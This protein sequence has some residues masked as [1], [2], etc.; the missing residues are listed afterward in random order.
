VFERQRIRWK[1]HNNGTKFND[2][3]LGKSNKNRLSKKIILSSSLFGKRRDEIVESFFH[4]QIW[5]K[6]GARVAEV[7]GLS[8]SFSILLSLF[9]W[10]VVKNEKLQNNEAVK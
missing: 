1:N 2:I 4:H 10:F 3:L 5:F 7:S 8:A 6:F 9:L